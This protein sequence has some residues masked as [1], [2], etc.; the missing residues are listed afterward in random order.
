[1]VKPRSC[2]VVVRY[3]L[4]F[5]AP[6]VVVVVL[7]VVVVVHPAIRMTAAIRHTATPVNINFFIELIFLRVVSTFLKQVGIQ[8]RN[9]NDVPIF[10]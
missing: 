4:T 8:R 1:M 7:F 9:K 10:Q 6:A 2:I 5:V 3:W